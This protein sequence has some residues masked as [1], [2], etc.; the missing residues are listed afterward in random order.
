MKSDPS[1]LRRL[2]WWAS[3]VVG[4]V[5]LAS[6]GGG[7][8]VS[9][10]APR[11]IVVFGDETS[12]LTTAGQVDPVTQQTYDATGKNWGVNA[13]D[14]TSG[15]LLC[16]NGPNWVQYLAQSWRLPFAQCNPSG[17]A[18]PSLD[19][20]I[21]GAKVDDVSAQIDS[22]LAAD[23]LTD[24]DLVTLLVGANDIL[25]QYALYDGTNEAALSAALEDRGTALAG[26]VHRLVD[27]GGKVIVLTVPDLGVT[28]FAIAEKAAHTDTDRA[29]LL[30]RLTDR[31]NAKLRVGLVNDSGRNVGLVLGDQVIQFYSRFPAAG[32]FVDVIDPA[33]TTAAPPDC[34]NKTLAT[35][36]DGNTWLWATPTL[37]SAGGQRQLG[38]AADSRSRNNPF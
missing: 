25:A 17:G 5:L 3:T 7:D 19:Y 32:G 23:S 15:A 12:A 36:A 9:A 16:Q 28:P 11:R 30:S 18:A 24:R 34:T 31:F 10:F 13:V 20:A 35:G 38:I 1:R 14:A 8:L 29:A 6:C 27:A 22:H 37:L 21:N 4:L 2:A 33:C 26:L